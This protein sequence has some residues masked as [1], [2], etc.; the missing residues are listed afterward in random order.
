MLQIMWKAILADGYVPEEDRLMV[1]DTYRHHFR[2]MLVYDFPQQC[3]HYSVVMPIS[4]SLP[5]KD[6][7]QSLVYFILLLLFHFIQS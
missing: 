6:E 5:H 2:N 7:Q 4:I 3:K 1:H